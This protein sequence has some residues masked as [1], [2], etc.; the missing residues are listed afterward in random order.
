MTGILNTNAHDPTFFFKYLA[1]THDLLITY[2]AKVM[3]YHLG[4]D[5]KHVNHSILR[6]LK[7]RLCNASKCGKLDT[8]YTEAVCS[9]EDQEDAL[10]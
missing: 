3:H 2:F 9:S 7:I 10:W 4:T 1:D 5:L 8:V 6:E